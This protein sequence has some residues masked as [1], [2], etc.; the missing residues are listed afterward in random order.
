L[1]LSKDFRNQDFMIEMSKLN[2]I[3]ENEYLKPNEDDIKNEN[4]R[5]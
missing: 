1:I 2:K 4:E 3:I 5:N